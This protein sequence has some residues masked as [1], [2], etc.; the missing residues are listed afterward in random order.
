MPFS[1][2]NF[3]RTLVIFF[4]KFIPTDHFA[5]KFPVSVKGVV[6]YKKKVILLQNS[7]GEWDL[8]GGKLHVGES[9]TFCLERE[10][11]EEI[12]LPVRVKNLLDVCLIKILNQIT[13]LI[14]LYKCELIS[15]NIDDIKISF[16]HQDVKFVDMD[17]LKS[18]KMQELYKS[19]ISNCYESLFT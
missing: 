18:I 8:P 5:K 7:L 1:F 4:S 9:I 2:D 15:D 13:V 19:I 12:N 16:E 3:L 11:F 10:I 17:E 6:F 14:I